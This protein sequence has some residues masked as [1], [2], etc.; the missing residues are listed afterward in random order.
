MLL[1]RS[2]PGFSVYKAPNILN[3]KVGTSVFLAG[4]IKMGKASEWQ[5]DFTLALSD[6]PVTVFNPRRDDW[7]L[8]WKQD[9]SHPKFREQVDWEMNRLDQVDTIALYFEPGTMSPISLLELGLY[10]LSGRKLVV[11]C[12]DGY[13]KRGNV[14]VLCERYGLL[15][16]ETK[17]ELI[18]HVRKRLEEAIKKAA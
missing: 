7:D 2:S 15:L 11:C 14:Q 6:L 12:P 18:G 5:I 8:T 4:S 16:V 10:A 1:M 13:W 3:K 17:E 9:I